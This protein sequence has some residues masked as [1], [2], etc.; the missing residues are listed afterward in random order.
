MSISW[1]VFSP[2][3]DFVY[4]NFYQREKSPLGSLYQVPVIGGREPKKILEHLTTIISFAPDGKRFAFFRDYLKTGESDLMLANLDGSDAH[5]LNKRSGQDWF[6]GVPAW[7]PDGRVIACP[8]G[9]DTGGTQLT[10]AEIPAAGGTAKSITSYKWRGSLFRPFWVKDGSALIFNAA[11]LPGNPTQIWRVS[12]PDGTAS[13]ITND[14][15]EYGTSSFGLTADSST[16]VTIASERTSK[17]WL[18]V[19]SEEESRAKKLTS[20]KYDGQAGLRIAPD[21]RVVYVTKT[22]DYPDIWIMNPDAT[23]Q[24]QLTSNEDSEFGVEV[25][26]DGR[27]IV[28]VSQSA[29]GVPHIWRMDM[30]GGNVKQLTQGEFTDFAPVCSPDGRRV[31]FVSWR[32]GEER[33]WKVPIDGGE[34]TQ[35]SNQPFTGS[36]FLSEGKL[37]FGSYFDD[38]V[39][40]PRQRSA[41]MSFDSGQIVKIFDHPPKTNF[42]RMLDE[43]TLLYVQEKD[44][45]ENI[46]TRPLEGGMPKQLTRFSSERIF[47]FASSRDDKQFAVV[48][49]TAS[50]DIVLIKDFK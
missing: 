20:G 6:S 23:A 16:I 38:Q 46:W 29:A 45:A 27:Y 18:A 44:E 19:A 43:Q 26:P 28:Y 12:Y 50:S 25:S 2:D 42:W 36:A 21:G 24:K 9:T 32:T 15:S 14:L 34:A 22:G 1:T 3:G 30:D 35:V 17:I 13:R 48:R 39:N 47:N 4:Y 37:I 8:I 10:L 11:E 31:I 49:G 7:S 40:P 41:F 33:Q 5:I